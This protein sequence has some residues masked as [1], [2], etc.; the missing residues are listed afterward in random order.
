MP[1]TGQKDTDNNGE[2]D[3]CDQDIDGDGQYNSFVL[4]IF[5]SNKRKQHCKT[6]CISLCYVLK[7]PGAKQLVGDVFFCSS[8]KL[9]NDCYS[10]V[11]GGHCQHSNNAV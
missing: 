5:T 7:D 4:D 11:T 6:Y 3:A 10:D 9:E 8:E 1:N 2:G